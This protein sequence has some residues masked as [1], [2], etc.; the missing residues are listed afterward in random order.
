MLY[1]YVKETMIHPFPSLST[2]S[3]LDANLIGPPNLKLYNELIVALA[4]IH[5]I[6]L[7]MLSKFKILV[8]GKHQY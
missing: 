6:H 5:C 8:S 2:E 3:A 7:C 1:I 4:V